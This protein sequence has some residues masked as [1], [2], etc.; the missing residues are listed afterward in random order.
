MIALASYHMWV[1]L[2][3]VS[4]LFPEGFFSE[5]SG[6]PPPENQHFYIPIR[7][8]A[9]PNSRDGSLERRVSLSL[10]RSMGRELER[11]WGRS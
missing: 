3:V 4:S 6:F 10:S 2:V 7:S 5:F 1:K 11:P 8:D 9:G